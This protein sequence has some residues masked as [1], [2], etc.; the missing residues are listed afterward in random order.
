M[1]RSRVTAPASGAAFFVLLLLLLPAISLALPAGTPPLAPA[2]RAALSSAADGH[3][4]LPWQR[5]FMRGLAAPTAAAGTARTMGTDGTWGE[6]PPPMIQEAPGVYDP[7]RQS[8]LIVG[9]RAQGG[10]NTNDVWEMSL[11]APTPTWTLLQTAGTPPPPRS[12]HVLLYDS[13]REHLL[14]FGGADA[15]T[16][17]DCWGLD[18]TVDPPEWSQGHPTG[19]L[20][21][22]RAYATAVFDSLNDRAILFGGA[23][24]VGQNGPVSLVGDLWA[25][26][27]T[28]PFAW[29][30]LTPTGTPPSA[31][32]GSPAIYDRLRQRM[33]LFG[34]FDV[35]ALSDEFTLSL[36]GSPAW[37]P[38]VTSGGPPPGRAI[39]G[40]VYAAPQDR[41]V[42][43]GGFDG[44][45]SLS[46]A[47]SLDLGTSAWTQLSPTGGPPSP[48]QFPATAYDTPHNRMVIFGGNDEAGT[49]LD[50]LWSL[51]LGTTVAWTDLG[52]RRAPRRWDAATAYDATRHVM[53][54]HGG[55]GWEEGSGNLV[56]SD[57]WVLSFGSSAAWSNPAA[58]GTPLGE[59]FGHTAVYD[60]Q[61]DR[62]VFFGGSNGTMN[63]NDVWALTGL[64]GTPAWGLLSP[65]GTPPAARQYHSAVYDAVNDRMVVFGG[66]TGMGTL[67]DVWALSFA[68]TPAWTQLAPTGVGPLELWQQSAA[69]DQAG[70]RLIVFGG[71]SLG[72]R[73]DVH[74]LTLTG[75]PVWSELLPTGTLPEARQAASMVSIGSRMVV[76]GGDATGTGNGARNDS[77]LLSLYPAP[78]WRPLDVGPRAPSARMGSCAAF[79]PVTYQMAIFGGTGTST[80]G[81]DTWNLQLDQAVPTM[82]S[83][84]SANAEPGRVELAWEITSSSG[85]VGVYRNAGDGRWAEL[86]RLAPDG[87]G[88]IAYVDRDVIAGSRYGYRLGLTGPG[89]E[90]YVGEVWV[91]VPES[92][93]FA[94]RGMTPNPAPAGA[95]LIVFSLPDASPARL[96]LVDVSGRQV[97][98]REVG[99]LGRGE[100]VVRVSGSQP[101][102]PG[103]YLVRLTQGGRSLT[104]KAVTIR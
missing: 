72:L 60:S 75:S 4:F 77:W 99:S 100:H 90:V 97:F 37:A 18:L 49:V 35:T 50:P 17:N 101:L 89:G 74:A 87:M 98:S 20:P 14:L 93:R 36:G 69:L 23:D 103:L 66:S 27:F 83:L 26:P 71:Q 86:D 19:T 2:T 76:F 81:A 96:E 80:E 30:E 44:A 5:Q 31:R 64:G 68:G 42:M 94:L 79:D 24:S 1:S 82:A 40:L 84:V 57:L 16:L 7:V 78:A 28:G 88:R 102:A 52:G 21:A 6:L 47:W 85:S 9:G 54:V 29:T 8:M 22:R 10:A 39:P 46:D 33:V 43:F 62:L 25:L 65:S 32:A 67:N 58:S 63:Q 59:R 70:N 104:A 92:A 34:G 56:R 45:G 51:S 55:Q 53:W 61:R 15:M 95:G 48:R 3:A 73:N 91:D 11:S 41:M 12:G 13:R 38:L